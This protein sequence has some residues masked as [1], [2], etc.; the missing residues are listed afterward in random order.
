MSCPEHLQSLYRTCSALVVAH[1]YEHQLRNTLG[2]ISSSVFFLKQR[3]VKEEV[4]SVDSRIDASLKRIETR[5]KDGAYQLPQKPAVVGSEPLQPL[6]LGD[7]AARLIAGLRA[8]EH[9]CIELAPPSV[10][11]TIA[12]RDEVELLLYCLV[13]N[14]I[15]A[16]AEG[17]TVQVRVL[18]RFGG[19]V[20]VED[21]GR[22]PSPDACETMARPFLTTKPGG[23]GLGWAVAALLTKN[24]GGALEL[25]AGHPGAVARL[26]IRP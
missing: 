1:Y 9:V 11:R 23:L 20:E 4:W 21:D 14:A 13:E 6:V 16:V 24:L 25:A 8:P 5:V 7:V 26:R 17:G 18:D 2:A 19:T 12:R 22:G 15:E 3:L 10:V